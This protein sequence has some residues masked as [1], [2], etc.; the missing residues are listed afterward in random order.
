L[1]HRGIV[2]DGIVPGTCAGVTVRLYPKRRLI[3]QL[4]ARRGGAIR[5][6]GPACSWPGSAVREEQST[7][8]PAAAFSRTASMPF[9]TPS[10]D[11]NLG[12]TAT[13]VPSPAIKRKR[14]VP[15]TAR[16]ISN[17][18]ATA[19]FPLL[20]HQYLGPWSHRV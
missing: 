17:R 3:D 13:T 14:K 20:M 9:T 15:S 5:R 18:P 1:H 11:V 2:A 10:I 6:P 19:Y 4:A 16:M 12:D 8:K 7:T